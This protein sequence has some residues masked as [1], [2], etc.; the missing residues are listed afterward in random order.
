MTT[1]VVRNGY[2]YG[3]ESV[4]I[5]QPI[6]ELQFRTIERI[7]GEPPQRFKSY[8]QAFHFQPSDPRRASALLEYLAA[9]RIPHSTELRQIWTARLGTSEDRTPADAAADPSV[10]ELVAL[11]AR[12]RLSS[13]DLDEDVH[14]AASENA[15]N[16]NSEGL[17]GQIQYLVLRFGPSQTRAQIERAGR[18]GLASAECSLEGRP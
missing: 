10:P 2:R 1:A 12:R 13:E 15:A 14:D 4:A 17:D 18:R 3:G 9:K 6:T 11:A 8:A 5:D 7:L 16:I